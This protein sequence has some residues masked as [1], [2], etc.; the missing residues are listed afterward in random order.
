MEA[1]AA[2]PALLSG[3]SSDDS[4]ALRVRKRIDAP[5]TLRRGRWVAYDAAALVWAASPD[6]GSVQTRWP[7]AER[8]VTVT[9]LRSLRTLIRSADGSS[10]KPQR[11]CSGASSAISQSPSTPHDDKCSASD[12]AVIF[13]CFR[14]AGEA[15]AQRTASPKAGSSAASTDLMAS[16]HRSRT[17][18]TPS[19]A[20]AMVDA[21]RSMNRS[22]MWRACST[23]RYLK[24]GSSI[25]PDG[26]AKAADCAASQAGPAPSGRITVV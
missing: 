13:A 23:A 1:S 26:Q 19:L 18:T 21:C 3:A 7:N 10:R 11:R 5:D 16:A 2:F 14:S 6:S 12:A 20:A 8:M 22:V 4:S 17:G 25:A 15:P 24:N 9:S